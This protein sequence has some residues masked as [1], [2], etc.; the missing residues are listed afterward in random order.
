MNDMS[1]PFVPGR[2]KALLD[3]A[4]TAP[5]IMTDHDDARSGICGCAGRLL[6]NLFDRIARGLKISVSVAAVRLEIRALCPF[7]PCIN[8]DQPFG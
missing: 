6:T 8:E 7:V 1:R 2:N 5:R 3:E 4:D